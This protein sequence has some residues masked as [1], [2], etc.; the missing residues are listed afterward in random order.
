MLTLSDC[1]RLDSSGHIQ[2]NL[3]DELVQEA[4]KRVSHAHHDC[5]CTIV[6]NGC[7]MII[8][9]R[10]PSVLPRNRSGAS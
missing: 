1:T 3:E 4:L 10:P 7:A 6:I 8:G 9:S 2:E 5:Y